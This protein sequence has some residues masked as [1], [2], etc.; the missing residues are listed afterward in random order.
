MISRIDLFCGEFGICQIAFKSI[1]CGVLLYF[2]VIDGYFHLV[3][4]FQELVVATSVDVLFAQPP[5]PVCLLKS[6]NPF[7]PV[8]GVLSRPVVG[9]AN[10]KPSPVPLVVF[11]HLSV[12]PR[13]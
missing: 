11:L 1:P 7:L 3:L 10:Q 9:V 6:S 5:V 2:P 13:V 12:N 4:H 8:V